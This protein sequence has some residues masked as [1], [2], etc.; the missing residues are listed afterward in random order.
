MRQLL[1]VLFALLSISASAQNTQKEEPSDTLSQE[2]EELVISLAEQIFLHAVDSVMEEG[3]YMQA[4]EVL[5]SLQSKWMKITG[6]RPSPQMYMRKGQIYVSLEEWQLLIDATNECIKYNKE[7]MPDRTAALIYSMQGYG[8]RNLEDYKNAIRSYEYA[9]S[10]Y[11][12]VGDYGSQGDML[13][14]IAYSYG[15]LEKLSAASSFYE[16]GFM[17]FLQ[18]FNITKKQLLQSNLKVDDSYKESVLGVF[19]VHLFNMAIYEQDYGDRLASKE[20]LLMS[21]HC[22]NSMARSEYQRIYGRH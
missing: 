18:Y 6:K 13:C 1:F 2:Q 21:S 16:K 14:N 4:L 12:K 17:K 20:Y 5:D 7:T 10:Y 19:A 11:S 22:G 9:V 15:K 8:Y 3:M